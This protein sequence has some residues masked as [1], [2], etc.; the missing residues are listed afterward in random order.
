[1]AKQ[2]VIAGA[3]FAGLST[4]LKLA[5][6]D[7]DVKLIDQKS[8]HLFKPGLVPLLSNSISEDK[9]KLDLNSFLKGTGVEFSREKILG[10]DSE[11]EVVETNSGAHNYDYLVLALGSEANSH[12]LDIEAAHMGYGLS[13]VKKLKDE[14]EDA[15][16]VSVVGA[17]H[18]GV[19]IASEISKTGKKT[20]V[21]STSTR[22]TPGSD[23]KVSEKVLENFN[24]K[25]ISFRGG[26]W[27]KNVE[28]DRLETGEGQKI[29]HDLVVWAGGIQ[30]AEVIRESLDVGAEGLPVNPGLCSK[31]HENVFAAGDSA[32]HG[33]LK[34]ARNAWEQAET[35]AENIA[36]KETEALEHFDKKDTPIVIS[37]G[38]TAILEN[39]GKIYSSKLIRYLET[40]IRLR[41][42]YSLKL[43]RLK[44][45]LM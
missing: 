30:A 31:K 32:D 2:V 9:I 12:G 34:T 39:N 23:F 6:K 21:I 27:V 7:F 18:T 38:E 45:K 4:A 10:I 13:Q 1:M 40:V 16:K 8:F 33:A 11:R 43:Q 42:F 28:E 14:L 25:D 5:A 24:S 36:K 35:V 29:E 3:G 26:T 17:G 44:L 37:L 19:E 15:E 22:P 41:Y 20:T